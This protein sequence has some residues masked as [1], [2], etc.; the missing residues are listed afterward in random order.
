MIKTYLK[1]IDSL[2]SIQYD[3]SL[4][5]E[6][7]YIY[8]EISGQYFCATYDYSEKEFTGYTIQSGEY[9]TGQAIKCFK[10]SWQP[11]FI[12]R[13]IKENKKRKYFR[14]SRIIR[15]FFKFNGTSL[16]LVDVWNDFEGYIKPKEWNEFF[17]NKSYIESS[18]LLDI[19]ILSK[20]IID[21]HSGN[22]CLI[23]RS[24][25]SRYKI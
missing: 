6:P 18:D 16:S 24:N 7:V 13:V 10:L 23:R 2:D 15:F 17:C 20:K 14:G 21:L 11:E 3:K 12:E 8:S 25:G 19:T 22:E 4:I 1:S 9:K 5:T